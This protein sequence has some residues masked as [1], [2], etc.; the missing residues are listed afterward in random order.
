MKLSSILRSGRA[1]ALV[2]IVLA[3]S[4]MLH[5]QCLG[6][7]TD[8]VLNVTKEIV[9]TSNGMRCFNPIVY[10][11]GNWNAVAIV[12][13]DSTSP[14][15]D[16][17]V[18]LGNGNSNDIGNR[19]DYVLSD[20]FAPQAPPPNLDGVFT[21]YA[22]PSNGMARHVRSGTA[23]TPPFNESI[24][25]VGNTSPPN[26]M[27]ILKLIRFDVTEV[28]NYTISIASSSPFRW[29]LHEPQGTAAWRTRFDYLALGS[30]VTNPVTAPITQ[31]GS[32]VIAV[33][34]DRATTVQV[35]D[36]CTLSVSLT[37]YFTP[38]A[39][40]VNP[41]SGTALGGNVVLG[42]SGANFVPGSTVQFHFL[43]NATTI[44]SSY[45]SPS[46]LGA[47]IPGNLLTQ[48]G[49]ASLTVTNPGGLVSG[50]V[51]F[52]VNNPVPSLASLTPN[53]AWVGSSTVQVLLGGSSLVP[54]S[55]VQVNGSNRQTTFQSN[56]QVAVNL[57]ASDLALAG[58]LPFRI[59]NPAPG[60]GTSASRLFEVRNHAPVVNSHTPAPLIAGSGPLSLDVFGQHFAPG[61]TAAW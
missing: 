22:G 2:T 4:P 6:T 12:N 39:S 46:F 15:S 9:T 8:L 43:G 19:C 53:Y 37:S 1:I 5:A 24:G 30:T 26:T 18:Q 31:L 7:I 41:T 11:N 38:I 42:I 40:T 49:N 10:Q 60:G 32:H 21:Q 14:A 33:Y 58:V 55:V 47:T 34:Q 29:R 36:S 54:S 57:S 20:G 44:P 45:A 17:D 48:G 23:R 3:L 51:G 50:A 59:V 28:G 13:K 52:T 56:S 35:N 27:S 25:W 16:W 61:L